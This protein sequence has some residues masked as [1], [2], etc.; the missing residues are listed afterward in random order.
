MKK[1]YQTMCIEMLLVE[2][3][4]AVLTGS[5]TSEEIEIDS[6]NVTVK[7]MEDGGTFDV[8]FD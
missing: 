8:S 3:E 6:E 2:S 4:G 7:E 5:V 1:V